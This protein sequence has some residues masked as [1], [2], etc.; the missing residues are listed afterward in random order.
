MSFSRKL[1]WAAGLAGVAVGAALTSLARQA[2]QRERRLQSLALSIAE[3]GGAQ[4]RPAL[5]R[6][7]EILEAS[8]RLNRKVEFLPDAASD[9]QMATTV[10]TPPQRSFKQALIDCYASQ[11]DTL[12]GLPLDV[13]RLRP[14]PQYDFRS[15]PHDGLLWYEMRGWGI[16]GRRF[17]E[18]AGQALEELGQPA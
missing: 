16:D 2:G 9:V 1:M 4:A 17:C 8:G 15:P 5:V 11:R 18:L 14:A 3:A 10:L 13:E 12:R 6:T 7:I